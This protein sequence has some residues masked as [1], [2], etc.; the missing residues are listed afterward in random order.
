MIADIRTVMWKERQE[1]SG[2]YESL[3]D[4][5]SNLVFPVIGLGVMAISPPLALGPGYV[6]S[7]FSLLSSIV[8]P[9]MVVIMIIAESFAGERE[10]RTLATLLASRLPDRAILFGKIAVPVLEALRIT[11]IS[12]LVSL[13]MSNVAHWNGKIMLYTPVMTLVNLALGFLVVMLASCLGVLISLRA[14]T[15]QQATQNLT[16]ALLSPIMLVL[17]PISMIGTVLPDSWK[18]AFETFFKEVVMT[19]D[20]TQV[21]I[22]VVVALIVIDLGLL[23]AAMARFRRARLILD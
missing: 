16:V 4:K 6:E 21:I 3:R 1:R 8:V 23:M 20:F 15:V 12:H 17:I 7:P 13:A 19:A 22:V 18:A 2:Q 10:R 5:V 11:I 9:L 14:P